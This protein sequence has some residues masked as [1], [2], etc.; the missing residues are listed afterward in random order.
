[1]FNS[2]IHGEIK[3]HYHVRLCLC[4]THVTVFS[5]TKFIQNTFPFLIIFHI[6][7][8]V[9]ETFALMAVRCCHLKKLRHFAWGLCKRTLKKTFVYTPSCTRLRIQIGFPIGVCCH[10]KSIKRSGWIKTVKKNP[11]N[12]IRKWKLERVDVAVYYF[13]LLTHQSTRSQR[14]A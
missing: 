11:G 5:S 12:M 8:I 14:Q 4:Y 2:Y 9:T 3:Y 10:L 13:R 7:L 1:M 6:H